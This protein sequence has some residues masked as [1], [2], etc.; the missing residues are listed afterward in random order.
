MLFQQ[1]NEFIKLIFKNQKQATVQKINSY[2]CHGLARAIGMNLKKDAFSEN[3]L[4]NRDQQMVLKEK[5]IFCFW[6]KII[7]ENKHNEKS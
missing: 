2:Y 4:K 1:Y 6:K 3:N 7:D 5:L